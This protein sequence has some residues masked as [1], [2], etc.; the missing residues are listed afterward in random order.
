MDKGDGK[1][2]QKTGWKGA[3]NGA[4]GA[5]TFLS[6]HHNPNPA[7]A[8]RKGA[9]PCPYRASPC[10]IR[11]RRKTFKIRT[12]RGLERRKGGRLGILRVPVW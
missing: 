7:R 10:S 6:V 8:S 9:P 3:A 11:Y 4:V 1:R 12:E 2:Q 5:R